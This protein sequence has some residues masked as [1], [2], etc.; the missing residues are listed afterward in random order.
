MYSYSGISIAVS[1]QNSIST[2]EFP[3]C[4]SD[5]PTKAPTKIRI[6]LSGKAIWGYDAPVN[7]GANILKLFKLGLP[8]SSELPNDINNAR[9]FKAASAGWQSVSG[10]AVGVTAQYL[11][12]LVWYAIDSQQRHFPHLKLSSL[13]AHVVMTMP[14][15]SSSVARAAMNKAFELT[16]ATH[17]TNVTTPVRFLAEQEASL[18]SILSNSRPGID[19]S[20]EV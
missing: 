8:C 10:G 2:A 14:A 13:P 1:S 6:N 16:K 3:K 18:L 19:A 11:K 5:V 4:G 12:E 7:D 20:I 17:L 15:V 9:I